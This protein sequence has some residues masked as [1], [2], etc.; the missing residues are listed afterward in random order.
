M[1]AQ[2]ARELLEI[3]RGHCPYW[4]IE[5]PPA[6]PARDVHASI[7]STIIWRRQKWFKWPEM[8]RNGEKWSGA[9]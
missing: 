5:A 2:K 3:Q 1:E 7:P 8:A 4:V 9:R 6:Y